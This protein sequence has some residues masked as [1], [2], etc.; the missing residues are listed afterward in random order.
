MLDPSLFL[1]FR[2]LRR[3]RAA[4][5]AGELNNVVVPKSFVSAVRRGTFLEVGLKYFGASREEIEDLRSVTSFME[6]VERFPVYEPFGENVV[7]SDFRGELERAV[8]DDDILAVLAEE[9]SFLNSESWL[10]SRTRKPFSAFIRAGAI[11]VEGG[12]E[13]FDRAVM[14]TL[15]MSPE[16]VPSGLTRGQR[17]RATAKWIAVGGTSAA[18]LLHPLSGVVVVAT[19]GY[20]LLFDP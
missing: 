20:F 19:T 5:N 4:L 6:E 14:K 3:V 10:V 17:L 9:W 15:K 13:L 8:H 12:R 7:G 1:S 11:A 18:S 2:S 16:K